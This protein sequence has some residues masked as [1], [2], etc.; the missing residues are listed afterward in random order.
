MSNQTP[1]AESSGNMKSS[2]ENP[3]NALLEACNDDPHRI[4]Q[5]YETHRRDRN[6]QQQ[7]Q[8]LSPAFQGF[9][10][11]PVLKKLVTK[12]PDFEDPRNCLVFWG[13]PP[14]RIRETIDA[15]QKTLRRVSSSI[16]LMPLEHLHITT[17]EMAHSRTADEISDMVDV[18]GSKIAEI[19]NFLPDHRS[20][21]VKPLVSF[22]ASAIALS[23]LPAAG[24]DMRIDEGSSDA[25]TY[26]HLR[27]DLYD[28]CQRTGV[29]V[30]SR[31]VVPSAHL[32]IA[33][34]VDQD[35]YKHSKMKELINALTSVN[36]DLQ[37]RH[38][39]QQARGG[40]H[41]SSLQWVVG[42]EKGLV[43]R[44]MRVWYGDGESHYE[45]RG[46]ESPSI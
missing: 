10:I 41:A 35:I 36:E 33:R 19:C 18:M 27:R 13:R 2:L 30:A 21:L 28:M 22:D 39:D 15:I 12:E 6:Q 40:K 20:R 37:S 43:C 5:R 44:K 4:Q 24:E 32:T 1:T 8:M 11:D 3:Y 17:L 23:F 45:G 7:L 38:W 34:F 29:P 25:Y 46:F 31:Y 26:H 9:N 16:W 14:Q 42:E